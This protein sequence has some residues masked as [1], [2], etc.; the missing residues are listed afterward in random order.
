LRATYKCA[1]R[2]QGREPPYHERGAR[3]ASYRD[4]AALDANRRHQQRLGQAG[5]QA[6]DPPPP[7][8]DGAR[9]AQ[10]QQQVEVVPTFT[11]DYTAQTEFTALRQRLWDIV[12]FFAGDEA[13]RTQRKARTSTRSSCCY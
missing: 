4:H 1:C 13:K 3:P 10:P 5:Q 6:E 8:R 12:A 2:R 11:A 7:G 9:R